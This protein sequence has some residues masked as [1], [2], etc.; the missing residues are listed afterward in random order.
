MVL[1]DVGVAVLGLLLL[2]AFPDCLVDEVGC[3]PEAFGFALI[4][5]D[6]VVDRFE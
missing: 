3:A 2:Q 4:G 1:V 6:V 5:L